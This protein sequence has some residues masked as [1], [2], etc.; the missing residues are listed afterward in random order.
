[1]LSHFHV[2]VP[3]IP[4]RRLAATFL[5]LLVSGGFAA[6]AEHPDDPT[7][8]QQQIDALNLR[9]QAVEQTKPTVSGGNIQSGLSFG[10]YGELKFGLQQNADDNGH[11]QNGFDAARVVLMPSYQIDDRWLFKAEIE[12]EHGGIA[13]DDDDKSGGAVEVEQAYLDW[14]INEHLHWR[15]PGIDEVAFGYTNLNHEPVFFYSVQ[16]P[17]LAQGLIPTTW[18]TGATSVHGILTGPINYQFQISSSIIDNGGNVRDTTAANG[19]AA[20]G[21][22]AGVSGN[23]A[24]QLARPT[25]GDFKQQNNTIAY[26]FRLDYRVPAISGLAGST[27]IYHSPNIVPRGAYASDSNGVTIDSLGHCALTMIDTELR[28]RPQTEGLELRAEAVGMSFS[29]AANLRANNDGDPENNVG[30][31]MWGASGEVAW[32]FRLP[33]SRW[34]LVPFY[35]YT[36]AVFQTQGF[37]VRDDNLPTGAGRLDFQT[38]GLAAFPNASVVLKI[39]YQHVRTGSNQKPNADHLLGGVGFFF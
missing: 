39:D 12:V 5:S 31:T 1:M 2:Y 11:W 13:F 34:E 9:L 29:N 10:A 8:L 6:A 7:T 14:T 19:P 17:E 18:Y 26:A 20:L 37:A 35:R 3:A 23:E 33:G 36:H 4:R 25:N 30:R 15:L 38:F 21:Y 27:S 22:P 24:L 32:H 16:R 28:Y